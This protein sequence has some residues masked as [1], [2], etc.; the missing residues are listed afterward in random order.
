ME[1]KIFNIFLKTCK[2]TVDDSEDPCALIKPL[3]PAKDKE[4]NQGTAVA[5]G[6]RYFLFWGVGDGTYSCIDV[7]R[8]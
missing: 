4:T 5:C 7:L 1:L 3:K 6:I 2:D 8:N